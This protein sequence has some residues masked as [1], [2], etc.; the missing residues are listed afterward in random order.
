LE[1]KYKEWLDLARPLLTEDELSR[2]PQLSAAERDRFIREFWKR[3][4]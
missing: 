2:F 4:S 1:L 3:H